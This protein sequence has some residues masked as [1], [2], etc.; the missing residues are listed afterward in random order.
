MEVFRGRAGAAGRLAVHEQHGQQRDQLQHALGEAGA[1][2]EGD[3]DVVREGQGG[4]RYRRA[5]DR[6]A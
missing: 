1:L 4:E 5:G 3:A 2:S 6:A